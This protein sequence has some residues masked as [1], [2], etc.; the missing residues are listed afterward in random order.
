MDNNGNVLGS[1]EWS[2]MIPEHS[3]RV[4]KWSQDIRDSLGGFCKHLVVGVGKVTKQWEIVPG[5]P[6]MFREVTEGSRELM[7]VS[8]GLRNSPNRGN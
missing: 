4:L 3:R 1:N 2:R 6:E 8:R 5:L 7:E